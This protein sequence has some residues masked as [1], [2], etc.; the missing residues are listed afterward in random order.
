M[1]D[2]TSSDSHDLTRTTLQ[3]VF[4]GVLIGGSAWVLRPFVIPLVWAATIVVATWPLVP[5]LQGWLG[6]SRRLAVLVMTILLLLV[7]VVPLYVAIST[8]AEH[9]RRIAEWSKTLTDLA[10]PAPPAWLASVPYVGATAAAR[11]QALAA[12]SPEELGTMLPYARTIATR[13][14]G[15][16]GGI[17]MVFVQFLITV[18]LAAILYANGEAV[19]ERVE[20]FARR[21]A[22]RAARKRCAWPGRR[23]ARWRSG[24]WSRR[25]CSRGSPASAWR[26][27]ACRWRRC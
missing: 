20:R 2:E 25:R 11:W 15:H 17:G 21:L 6:G 10:V 18:V 7:L 8:I 14:A 1:S 5:R 26:S 27:R 19:A 9:A 23:Y 13:L 16:V 4:L 12:S 24:S 3:L 22:G